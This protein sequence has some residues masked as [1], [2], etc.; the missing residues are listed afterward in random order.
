MGK[1]IV[2]I[3]KWLQHLKDSGTIDPALGSYGNQRFYNP[4]QLLDL[5][6]TNDCHA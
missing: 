2:S 6:L 3:L 4:I 1:F 5:L